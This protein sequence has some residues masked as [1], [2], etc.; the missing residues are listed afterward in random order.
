[1]LRALLADSINIK[2]DYHAIT[3]AKQLL[4]SIGVDCSEQIIVD[5]CGLARNSKISPQFMTK[6]LVTMA[7]SEYRDEYVALFPIAGKDGTVKS[8]LHNTRL[9]GAFALK[10][11]SMSGVLCYSGYK[12][13]EK[14]EP[15]HAITIMVNNFSCKTREIR[16]AI[17]RYLL[18]IF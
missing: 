11:G 2:S 13:D 15:T 18:E 1:M 9:D 5:G 8:M 16:A 6:L 14:G 12:L 3:V 17:E 4:L 10:S 7:N